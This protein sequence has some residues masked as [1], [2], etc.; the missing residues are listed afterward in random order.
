M[1]ATRLSDGLLVTLKAID[2]VLHPFEI[3]IGQFLS[4]EQ[5]EQD[6][7]NHCVRILEVLQDP[8]DS[9]L[10]I[11][12]MPLLKPFRDPEFL[13]FGEVVAFFKQVVEVRSQLSRPYIL[14]QELT[15]F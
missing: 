10:S 5:L 12:V 1:D 3:E 4:S 14:C 6:P 11:I 8:I 13:T 15:H 9:L 7:R 2:T